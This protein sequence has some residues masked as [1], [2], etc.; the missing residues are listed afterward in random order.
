VDGDILGFSA[1]VEPYK[2]TALGT[3]S[4][5]TQLVTIQAKKLRE[6]CEKEPMLGYRLMA[7]VARLLAHRLESARIQLAAT[8]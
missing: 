7:Q 1:I 3:A 6:L 8:D 4:K 2:Y 5:E